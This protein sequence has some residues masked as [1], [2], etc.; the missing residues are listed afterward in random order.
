MVKY[1]QMTWFMMSQKKEFMKFHGTFGPSQVSPTAI[2]KDQK[3]NNHWIISNDAHYGLL[4]GI[5]YS[6]DSKQN[7]FKV[8]DAHKLEELD[9]F[10]SG[11]IDVIYKSSKGS[12]VECECVTTSTFRSRSFITFR[13]G[14]VVV[15]DHYLM[16]FEAKR[17]S[18]LICD[19]FKKDS[20]SDVIKDV[21]CPISDCRV[22]IMNGYDDMTQFIL[23]KKLLNVENFPDDIFGLIILFE[24]GY[25]NV[26]VHLF[27]RRFTKNESEYH[28]R[29][30]LG[31]ILNQ[32]LQQKGDDYSEHQRQQNI[33]AEK[34][35][36]LQK[37]KEREEYL[38][39]K[40]EQIEQYL[41]E[42]RK[43][44]F[45]EWQCQFLNKYQ[46]NDS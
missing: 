44:S 9:E 1:I 7:G 35:E 29:M 31:V 11:D 39:N 15:Y 12:L 26:N 6:S 41:E 27:K 37:A 45:E 24:G 23:K 34:Q 10:E 25:Y 14:K 18:I 43:L 16:G 21:K 8:S 17:G 5:E 22:I 4:E 40:R 19:I 3:Q 42:Q 36:I 30:N 33:I 20:E 38:A 32:Y 28:E 46:K 13:K 2:I